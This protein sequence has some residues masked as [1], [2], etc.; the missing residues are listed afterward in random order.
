MVLMPWM[1]TN[2]ASSVNPIRIC[3]SRL[4]LA[5]VA[6]LWLL[7]PSSALMMGQD[8]T[9]AIGIPPFTQ[10]LP[11]ESGFINANNGDLHLEIPLGSFPERAGRQFKAVLMY[12]SMI[13]DC[14]LGYCNPYNT[15]DGNG[16]SGTDSATYSGW[17]LVTSAHEGRGA[18]SANDREC[19]VGRN[20]YGVGQITREGF[21]WIGPDGTTHAFPSIV[22]VQSL[23]TPPYTPCFGGDTPNSD[24]I[25]PDGS[26]YHMYV[27]NY[28][29]IQIYGPD[30]TLDYVQDTNGNY[31]TNNF[32]WNGVGSA[33][34]SSGRPL[35][36]VSLNGNY[37]YYDVLNSQGTTSRYTV[38]TA[39]IPIN[40]YSST[41]PLTV[42][43]SI[44][45]PDLTTYQFGYDSGAT[46]THS[47][48]LT[49]MTLPTGG[50]VSYSRNGS[51]TTRTT[52]DSATPWT[53][54]TQVIS[55]CTTT[56]NG[57]TQLTVQKPSG[58][59]EVLTFVC[60][61]AIYAGPYPTSVQYYSG[62][63]S[64][65]NLV[66]TLTAEYDLTHLVY[67]T[68]NNCN[69]DPILDV[70]KTAESTILPASGGTT[71]TQR[72]EY[73][74]DSGGVGGSMQYG[75]LLQKREWNFYSGTRPAS[76]D[77]T[78]SMSY[79]NGSGYLAVNIVNRPV[80]VTVTNSSG[81]TVAQAVNSYDD[82][83]LSTTG[84][85]GLAN[86]N[87]TNYGATNTVRGNLTQAKRWLNTTGGFLVISNHYDIAGNLIQ[88][89]DPNGNSTYFDHTDNYYGA[90]P[91]PPTAA[92]VTKITK[93]VTNSVNHIERFQYYYGS[94]LSAAICGENLPSGSNCAYGM[95]VPQ[96]DY[97][98]FSYDNMGRPSTKNAGD[99]GQ[100][101]WS[102]TSN[103][104][105][106]T[107][108]IDGSHN[109]VGSSIL[110]G[111]G[112]TSQGQTSSGQG[113][114]YVDTTY[115]SNGRVHTV[116]NPHFSI[117]S[118]TDGVTT[119]FSYDGLDRVRLVTDQDGSN[120]VAISYAGNCKTVTDEANKARKSCYD[121]FGRLTGVWEDPSGLNY[122]TDYLYDLLND[123]TSV[124]QS[125]SR[126]RTF[127]YD[128]LSRLTS[129]YNPES[130]TINY[131]YDANG[132]VLTKTDARNITT[133]YTYDALNR[134]Q[135]KLYSDG[136]PGA[137]YYYD[138]TAPWGFTLSNPIG[139]LT[140]E[141]TYNGTTWPTSSA[142]SYDP[143]GRT[144]LDDQCTPTNCGSTGWSIYYTYNLDG[145]LTSFTNTWNTFYQS[146]DS[147]GRVTQLT[148]SFVDA[149]HPGTL[150][151]VNSYYP[152]GQVKQLTLG[153]GLIESNVFNPRLQGCRITLLSSGTPP[154]AC[155]D[156]IPSGNVEDFA[157]VFG[158]T[159]NNGNITGWNGVGVQTF[160]RSYTYDG[161]NRL[162]TLSDS[163]PGAQCPSLSWS[164]DN[165]G[166]R[167]QS[168]CRTFSAAF[169]ASNQI[170]SVGSINFQY[171]AAGNLVNDG[172][173]HYGYDAEN[174]LTTVDSGS[175]ATYLY[176]AEG[177][178]VRSTTASGTFDYIYDALSGKILYTYG[179][180]PNGYKGAIV[181]Y[182]PFQG[183]LT[184]FYA[185]ST[186]F[187]VHR[188]HLG[189]TR[190]TTD[191]NRNV[192]ETVD[193]LPFGELTLSGNG[194][195]WPDLLF[196][197]KERDWESGLDNF[198][199]R[200][201]SSQYG[202][203]MTPD[204]SAVPEPV[205]FAKLTNPQ[206]LNLYAFVHDNPVTFA[207][208]DG[209]CDLV[210]AC[211]TNE[212]CGIGCGDAW[213]AAGSN[214]RLEAH[215]GGNVENG[216]SN[217]TTYNPGNDLL[218]A[219][220]NFNPFVFNYIDENGAAYPGSFNSWDD[221]AAWA[222]SI[223]AMSQAMDDYLNGKTG[224]FERL[225][226]NL[227]KDFPGRQISLDPSNP[228]L[229]GGHFNFPMTC[230][231]G[232]CPQAGRY[233]NGV[234][235]EDTGF[236]H[237]DTVSPWTGGFSFLDL[238]SGSFYEH[239]SI[240][241][242]GG[243]FFV[244]VFAQ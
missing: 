120:S 164:Y 60:P 163:A 46:G 65:A 75:E 42:I 77:R 159:N 80:S 141:G 12:D 95:S 219:A 128:S 63:V 30:G 47:G 67:S 93:P 104:S 190:A 38:T 127:S 119:Y 35:V 200:Y 107:T 106:S 4:G 102:Y 222:T 123:L 174:R 161:V 117:S 21:Y 99:G 118:P 198:G 100:T 154:A 125:G 81:S 130:N 114:I 149:Q 1:A 181:F 217:D 230:A 68:A 44:Q 40:A 244:P 237:N 105:T 48:L 234:H 24:Q 85:T 122:E 227:S 41:T 214:A 243:T 5:L 109:L 112:R 151:T 172:T 61:M 171:D 132:N 191:L 126:Q 27:T 64:S 232:P 98:S 139:R 187:F 96:S 116:S 137:Y 31:Y 170:A 25:A 238:F 89:T 197:G 229:H 175:T 223:P 231:D 184:A 143:M 97:I 55:N 213:L 111:L 54:T 135:S 179:S 76:A 16:W 69:C 29:N 84:A 33:T 45:L 79:L 220:N 148:S 83:P 6:L 206:T 17:R 74:W 70:V 240:D 140:T 26:G 134:L 23:P 203:F 94:G 224:Q 72:T 62:S 108:T 58:D 165:W 78:T 57:Y 9:N 103:S 167:Q 32:N 92:Y 207:D 208:S 242:I 189:T 150:A 216:G 144:L 8:Y 188:D 211:N 113:T 11:V 19:V 43:Q 183:Q 49:S 129:A 202:R 201:D 185:S 215:N 226:G 236:V 73:T 199:A 86:H 82:W 124:T 131:A 194:N 235:I 13:W 142:F 36:T 56:A 28:W 88:T 233:N 176:D 218:N 228:V 53:Y 239:G 209:H 152:S 146:F 180:L 52:P 182:V 2:H 177:R 101:S 225:T 18:Y 39:Q 196:T 10:Q 59:S 195:C 147:A 178:R 145:G 212:E 160:N 155:G 221:Y 20:D 173:H 156:P 91:S 110:D 138:Q 37:I 34:D 66:A 157:Y 168:G 71:L 166:N 90:S 136:T 14:P 50:Q 204:W 210:A 192:C 22:T 115:D 153:N 51:V 205:P 7:G 87:D 169:N 241:L 186:T 162:W 133:T 121:G 15:T 158:G 3:W 193:N